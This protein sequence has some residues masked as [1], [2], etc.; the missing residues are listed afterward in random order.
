MSLSL[1]S[2]P[3]LAEV[4][5]RRSRAYWLLAR[6]FA[7][8]PSAQLFAELQQSPALDPL[9]AS[10]DPLAVE[11]TA[12]LSALLA[13]AND[14]TATQDLAIEFTRLFGG[15]SKSYGA[16]PPFES[17]ARDAAWGGDTV[18][19]VLE[20]YADAGIS[21][22]LPEAAPPDHLSA[23]LRFLAIACYHEGEAWTCGDL[24][25]ASDWLKRERDFLD[26]HIL[27]WVP[28]YCA[29]LDGLA[30][31]PLYRALLVLTPLACQNDRQDINDMLDVVSS[32][33]D[34]A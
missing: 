13:A 32:N 7:E 8:V 34:D 11:S 2:D 16:A 12:L 5:G 19:A 3:E 25:L 10:D 14:E 28:D 22:P 23:E 26:R 29:R 21:P 27:P 20:A 31:T 18:A 33:P 30:H 15:I 4:A 17:V 24:E 6:C 9:I 1:P